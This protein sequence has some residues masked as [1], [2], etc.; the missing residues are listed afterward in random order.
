M[1]PPACQFFVEGAG[2]ARFNGGYY[3]EGERGG[4]PCF[5]KLDGEGEVVHFIGD[6]AWAM[7][8]GFSTVS[9]RSGDYSAERPAATGWRVLSAGVAPAPTVRY[10]TIK[11]QQDAERIAIAAAM[12]EAAEERRLEEEAKA[13]R[14][15]LAEEAERQRLAEE[16]ERERQRLAA[17]AEARRLAE[18]AAAAEAARLKKIADDKARIASEHNHRASMHRTARNK[19]ASRFAQTAM[20]TTGFQP[21]GSYM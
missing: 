8:V 14:K 18:E 1:A 10:P 17:E 2:D 9:Y 12:A 4:K 13:E 20:M 19:N 16:A 3:E 6:T 11:Q 15:R 21:T 7:S 5:H